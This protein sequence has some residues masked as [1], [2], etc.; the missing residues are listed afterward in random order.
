MCTLSHCSIGS[1]TPAGQTGYW[2]SYVLVAVCRGITYQSMAAAHGGRVKCVINIHLVEYYA[3]VR[4]DEGS[5]A[6]GY[7]HREFVMG[8]ERS[9]A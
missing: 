3:P 6:E 7:L 5:L 1:E 4:V 9:T 8:V 2:N